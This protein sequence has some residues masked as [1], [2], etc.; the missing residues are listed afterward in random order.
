MKGIVFVNFNEFINELWGDEFW[1]NLLNGAELSSGGVCTTFGTYDDQNFFT[2][3]CLGVDKKNIY[4]K[5]AQFISG[6]RVFREFYSF[7]L[8]GVYNFTGAFESAY[9]VQSF[10]H[11]EADKM[12]TYT[13]HPKSMFLSETPKKFLSHYQFAGKLYFLC[14]DILPSPTTHTGQKVKVSQIGCEHQSG[15]CSMREVEKV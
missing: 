6:K 14:E 7:A 3:I 9:T 12:D 4:V 8:A 2:L 15:R 1:D 11:L 10:I 13:L 5:D